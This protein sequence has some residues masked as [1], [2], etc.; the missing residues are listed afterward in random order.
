MSR[1]SEEVLAT[2]ESDLAAKFE[3]YSLRGWL[4]QAG[5]LYLWKSVPEVALG[6]ETVSA[7][8]AAVADVSA[9][10]AHRY[11]GGFISD[12]PF[13]ERSESLPAR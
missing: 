10:S 6:E 7:I 3:R 13:A 5:W 8:F 4:T 11:V 9:D 12:V 1:T 2:F